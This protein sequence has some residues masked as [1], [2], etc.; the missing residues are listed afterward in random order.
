MSM[1]FNLFSLAPSR[2]VGFAPSLL[3]AVFFVA[4]LAPS[5]ALAQV[6]EAEGSKGDPGSMQ[7]QQKQMMELQEVQQELD[8]TREQA[9]AKPA[10]A[11]KRDDLQGKIEAAM[12]KE[13]PKAEK[14]LKRFEKLRG[15]F[16]AANEAGNQE[17]AQALAGEL[18]T[19]G[20]SLQ[21]TQA[22]VMKNEK[23]NSAATSFQQDLLA[24]MKKLNPKT[25]R[26]L[27]RAQTLS[28]NLRGD[29]AMTPPSP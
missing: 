1:P 20:V 26:L 11:K 15:E 7:A 4:L 8:K 18:Q 21:Q 3:A 17:R 12:A 25:E 10:L 14:Q 19:L 28:Q 2:R 27:A 22:K 6:P 23:I 24:Q 16:D 5:G 13:N 9:L 29:A